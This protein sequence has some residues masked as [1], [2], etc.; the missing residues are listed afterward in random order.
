MGLAE[1]QHG[2]ETNKSRWAPLGGVDSL[3]KACAEVRRFAQQIPWSK[4]RRLE[5]E[6]EVQKTAASFRFT[7]EVSACL[8]RPQRTEV[9]KGSR[10]ILKALGH[11]ERVV[12]HNWVS[13]C[14]AARRTG[15]LPTEWG[16][17]ERVMAAASISLGKPF[18][19]ILASAEF[20]RKGRA[21]S[22]L[23]DK[24]LLVVRTRNLMQHFAGRYPSFAR[25]NC[26]L[27][28]PLLRTV[29]AVYEYATGKSAGPFNCYIAEAEKAVKLKKE[30]SLEDLERLILELSEERQT[31][32]AADEDLSWPSSISPQN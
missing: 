14:A 29:T 6:N 1:R 4:G 13:V 23:S 18:K 25:D 3:E 7:Q 9:R 5:L 21:E 10:R 15:R 16:D 22:P 2:G 32:E 8:F 19:E 17:F 11:L 30:N 27:P 20:N 12:N 24:A 28:G 31:D 26:D